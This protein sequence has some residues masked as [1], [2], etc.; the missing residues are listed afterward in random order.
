M[1]ELSRLY[2]QA[3]WLFCLI[4]DPGG[5]ILRRCLIMTVVLAEMVIL[6]I[7]KVATSFFFRVFYFL[8]SKLVVSETN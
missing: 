4:C 3:D 1:F 2:K 7:L 8:V 5:N 6:K